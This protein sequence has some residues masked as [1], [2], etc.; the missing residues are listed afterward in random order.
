MAIRTAEI[1]RSKI[2]DFYTFYV[3]FHEIFGRS[4]DFLANFCKKRV[5]GIHVV[6]LASLLRLVLLLWV[7]LLLL[8]L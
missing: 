7:S 1:Y 5:F 8:T 3:V 4:D 2:G 6:L